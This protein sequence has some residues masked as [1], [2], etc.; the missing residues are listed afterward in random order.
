MPGVVACAH[1]CAPPATVSGVNTA[2]NPVARISRVERWNPLA[3]GTSSSYPVR[4]V[5]TEYYDLFQDPDGTTMMI[6]TIAVDDPQFLDRQYI[7]I[8][9]FKKE[10]DGSKWDPSPCSARW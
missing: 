7:V 5:L 8:A 2:T 6:V 3:T 4:A 1:A 10:L 9:H